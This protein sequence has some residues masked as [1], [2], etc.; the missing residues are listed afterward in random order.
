MSGIEHGKRVLKILSRID[1]MLAM[2]ELAIQVM[3]SDVKDLLEDA[4]KAD[5]TLLYVED[6]ELGRL[7]WERIGNSDITEKA[8]PIKEK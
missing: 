5:E 6:R 1:S 3:S 2:Q 4:A 7:L 8:P